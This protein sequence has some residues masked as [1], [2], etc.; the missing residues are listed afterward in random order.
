[1]IKYSIKLAL[2]LQDKESKV[3]PIYLSVGDYD[4]DLGL[5]VNEAFFID[6]LKLG[7]KSFSFLAVVIKLMKRLTAVDKGTFEIIA[8]V[9]ALDATIWPEMAKNLGAKIDLSTVEIQDH[10]FAK[11]DPSSIDFKLQDLMSMPALH[12]N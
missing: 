12:L 10:L 1:M 2:P 11:V 7:E 5:Q 9:N 3:G 8:C 6:D 4:F